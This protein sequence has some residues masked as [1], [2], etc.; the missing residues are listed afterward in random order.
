MTTTSL[1]TTTS[2]AVSTTI[3][4]TETTLPPTASPSNPA[5]SSTAPVP[6][7]VGSQLV[8]RQTGQP[9]RLLGL[10]ASGTETAC[11]EDEGF[12]WGSS[13]PA[14]AASIASWDANVVRVPLNEDCWLGING[15]PPEYSGAAYQEK[16]VQWV[17]AINGAGMV[18]ILDLH[19]SAP[20]SVL[21][22]GMWPMADQDHSVTFWSQV[23]A[24]FS[25]YPSVVFDLFNEPS[26]GNS[27]P[28]AADWSCWLN[29]CASSFDNVS[30]QV[31]GMQELLNT[32]RAAGATQPVMVGG[33]N[34][35]GDP[36][37]IY[38]QG[39]N[40]G[41]CAWLAYA[42]T[43][44]DHQLIDSFHTYNWTGCTSLSC[45]DTSV[46]PVAASVPVVTG[47]LGE[48]DCSASYI[49]T[50]MQWADQHDISYLAWD[51]Q[52]SPA[53]GQ[54]C[55]SDPFNL[56]SNWGGTPSTI[57]P[58]GPAFAAHLAALAGAGASNP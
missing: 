41:S 51:W 46:L 39:G 47:E 35:A 24:T 33:L 6:E 11:I 55:S 27:D 4:A 29:G 53:A 10:D 58:A 22:S 7:V 43:D 20:G 9:L 50:Y 18:A 5:G 26:L 31:A 34:Y 48:D 57:V 3:S 15:A 42:P 30:Y 1:A 38:D 13:D 56:L 21:S 37:G 36:C 54:T 19:D 52:A 28:T 45:W 16:I 32:V 12:A 8:N 2:T 17:Q 14:E 49:D 40:G 25:S 44:P 23:A